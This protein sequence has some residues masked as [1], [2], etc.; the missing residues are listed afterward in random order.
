MVYNGP[1]MMTFSEVN[2]IKKHHLCTY[3]MK[4]ILLRGKFAVT[5]S[6]WP[7]A[8]SVKNISDFF[9]ALEVFGV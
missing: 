5:L 2:Q 6:V 1:I 8:T 3:S 9:S 4:E 7:K